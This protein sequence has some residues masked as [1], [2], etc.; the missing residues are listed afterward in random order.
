MR[1][2]NGRFGR[3]SAFSLLIAKHL[4]YQSGMK[5]PEIRHHTKAA[6]EFIADRL[7]LRDDPDMQDWEIEVSEVS[8]LPRYLALFYDVSKAEDVRFTLADMILEAF[9]QSNADLDATPEWGVFLSTLA[10][11]IDVHGW[12]IWCWAAWEVALQDAWRV[13]PYMRS[14]C[15][16][17]VVLE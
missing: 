8:D 5:E 1:F 12:Q 3:K 16:A 10:E 7:G 2:G 9:E 6:R 15:R 11:R 17:H 14:L 13:T 4:R